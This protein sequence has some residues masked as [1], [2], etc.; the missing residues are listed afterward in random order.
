MRG[1]VGHDGCDT[2]PR[3]S[4]PDREEA[5][6]NP[7]LSLTAYCDESGDA[8]DPNCPFVGMGGLCAPEASSNRSDTQWR[9]ILDDQCGGV[10]FHMNDFASREGVFKGWKEPRRRRLMRSLVACIAQAKARPFGAVV[11]LDAYESLL[12]AIPGRQ[13][14]GTV[15]AA[16]PQR[17]IW[18]PSLRSAERLGAGQSP[19]S[20]MTATR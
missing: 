14:E 4:R 13:G 17:R 11:S 1:H 5:C 15:A 12:K 9:E 18:L 10:W 6:A 19:Q 20:P 7:M 8:D 16:C 3:P 2:I